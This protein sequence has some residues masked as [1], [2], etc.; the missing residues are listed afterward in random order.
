MTV[1]LIFADGHPVVLYG[2]RALFGPPE[3]CVVAECVDGRA[4]LEAVLAHMP[5][6]LIV[7]M[8]IR[9]VTALEILKVLRRRQL[10]TR[11]VVLAD[12]VDEA[13][14]LDVIRC[15]TSGVLPKATGPERLVDCVRAVAAGRTYIDSEFLSR[16]LASQ[17]LARE[18]THREREI[19]RFIV[20]G[21]RNKQIA[22]EMAISEGTV[23]MHLHN[24]YAKLHVATR[25]E[26]ALYAKNNQIT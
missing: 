1:T 3:F 17:F 21:L 20:S 12:H 4:T 8:Q 11:A 16:T 5:D 22:D 14:T 9:E 6:V 26:F 2:L 25:T 24:I 7:D 13:T 15:A 18:L 19:A 10:T 23:K